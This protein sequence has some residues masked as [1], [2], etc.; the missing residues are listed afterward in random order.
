MGGRSSM[1][2][3]E[4]GEV[5][6]ER[7]AEDNV[8]CFEFQNGYQN[9][10]F[11]VTKA[12]TIFKD[13]EGLWLLLTYKKHGWSMGGAPDQ[14][15]D[16]KTSSN[17]F[18]KCLLEPGKCKNNIKDHTTEKKCNA[19][20]A[21][22]WVSAL[23][24]DARSNKASRSMIRKAIITCCDLC[25]DCKGKR[26]VYWYR[27]RA[28]YPCEGCSIPCECKLGEF[29]KRKGYTKVADARDQNDMLNMQELKHPR[30]C[31]TCQNTGRKSTGRDTSG[32]LS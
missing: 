14:W 20:R 13:P 16:V 26:K 1:S 21:C 18:L 6:V 27:Y 31:R 3:T 15:I 2:V 17:G 24:G 25:A 28:Y 11:N 5:F 4:R 29:M 8:E 32:L 9:T 22:V 10:K 30:S 19:A 7:D 23:K 12:S